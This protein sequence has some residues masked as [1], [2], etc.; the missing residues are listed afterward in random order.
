MSD[1]IDGLT[2]RMQ[3]SSLRVALRRPPTLEQLTAIDG[4]TAAE[5]LEGDHLRVSHTPDSNPAEA[6]VEKAVSGGW[7]LYELT[8]ERLSLEDVFVNITTTDP[9][10]EED[11]A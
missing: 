9:V 11:A 10:H 8:P 7:G 1:T 3:S 5:L 6:I 2:Q 4:I